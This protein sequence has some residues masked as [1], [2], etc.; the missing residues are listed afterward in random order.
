MKKAYLAL[1]CFNLI[2]TQTYTAEQQTHATEQQEHPTEEP[3]LG[4]KHNNNHNK[5]HSWPEEEKKVPQEKAKTQPKPRSLSLDS[6][7]DHKNLRYWQ[8]WDQLPSS[9]RRNSHD[10]SSNKTRSFCEILAD[11]RKKCRDLG[12]K[13]DD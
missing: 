8:N 2:A 12:E 3:N 9:N 4:Q 10:S 13:S 6:W 5:T 11:L 1:F 7:T